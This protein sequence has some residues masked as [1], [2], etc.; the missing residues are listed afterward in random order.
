MNQKGVI[1]FFLLF[2]L[3]AGLLT[4]VY[5]VTSGNPLKLFSKAANPPIVFKS[6]DG[7]SLPSN[8]NGIPQ[9][10][11]PNVR[12]EL[13]STLGPPVSVSG[14]ISSPNRTGT[15]A[16]RAG[17][18]P[19]DLAGA[20]FRHYSK[21]PTVYSVGFKNT[22]GVQFYWVEF[23]DASGKTEI[24]SAQI[25]LV[26]SSCTPRPS[27]L[28]A[29]PRCLMPEPVGG[30]CIPSPTPTPSASPISHSISTPTPVSSVRPTSLIP[31]RTPKLA[32]SA[33]PSPLTQTRTPPLP[34]QI[35]SLKPETSTSF[36]LQQRSS[37]NIHRSVPPIPVIEVSPSPQSNVIAQPAASNIPILGGLLNYFAE[38]MIRTL[39]LWK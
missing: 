4:G 13:T 35:P 15:V 2:V 12:V 30:W 20:T 34:T 33:S 18:D 6:L 19:V 24:R 23:K 11:F 26:A 39:N 32:P 1:H 16:Y 7:S 3:L 21:E 27:C 38:M 17:F 25:E 5:L 9:T 10:T 37:Q 36:Q 8:P 29:R 14:P 31:T 22:P 28:D